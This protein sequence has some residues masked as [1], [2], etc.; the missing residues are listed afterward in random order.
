VHT[1]SLTLPCRD[2]FDRNF[3]GTNDSDIVA[4]INAAMPFALD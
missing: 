2:R 1:T 3:Q 4:A